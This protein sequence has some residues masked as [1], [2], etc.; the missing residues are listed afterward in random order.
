M[1][2]KLS[3]S[4][5]AKAKSPSKSLGGVAVLAVLAVIALSLLPGVKPVSGVMVG[6]RRGDGA[7]STSVSFFGL[8]ANEN[9]RPAF[10]IDHPLER[11]VGGTGMS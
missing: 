11:C 6:E 9:V 4:E 3:R 2:P 1:F 10:L 7:L 5:V 8:L